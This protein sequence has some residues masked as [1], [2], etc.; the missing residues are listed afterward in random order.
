MSQVLQGTWAS[1]R[2]I[3]MEKRKT[4]EPPIK[5]RSDGTVF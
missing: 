3:A 2:L 5:I 1:G 4:S